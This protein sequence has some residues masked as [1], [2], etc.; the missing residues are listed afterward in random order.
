M[1]RRAD[2]QLLLFA[3][4]LLGVTG[5]AAGRAP[6]E[7]RIEAAVGGL[8]TPLTQAL[9]GGARQASGALSGMRSNQQL[10]AQVAE[11][12]ALIHRLETDG[13]K[14]DDLVRE[15]RNLRDLLAFSRQR[16]DLDLAGASLAGRPAGADPGNV[17]HLV[18]L[19]LGAE[20]GVARRMPVVD[21]RGLV[22]QVIAVSA[23]WSDVLLITDPDS[24]V[25]GRVKR[26]GATGMVF[27]T[28]TGELVM[29]YLPQAALGAEAVIEVDDLV[30]TSGLSEHFPA[31]LLVGQVVAVHQSDVEPHQEAL[32]RPSV[33]FNALDQVLVVTGWRPLAEEADGAAEGAG[34]P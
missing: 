34:S 29:R 25:E 7:S 12:Q 27:G 19:D 8:L 5:L 10:S 23:A 13:Q 30:Y 9:A 2:R 11:Q 28:P 22:G 26:S 20:R 17:R 21:E 1:D 15:N 33:D 14:M 3:A 24:R 32:I 18:R 31:K 4:V 16:V 6:G